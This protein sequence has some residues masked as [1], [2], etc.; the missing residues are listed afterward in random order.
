MAGGM[1]H[2]GDGLPRETLAERVANTRARQTGSTLG[3][4]TADA[5]GQP[6]TAPASWTAP[7][8]PQ[9]VPATPPPPLKHCWYD[10]EPYG[11]QPALLVKWRCTEGHYDGLIIVAAPDET[12]RGWAVVEMW[13]AA[14][15]LS[16][17]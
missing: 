1:G 4:S 12:G 17:A 6:A 2:R 13:V 9:A 14:G 5:H 10:G 16:P 8:A 7:A 3:H 11:R 15:L